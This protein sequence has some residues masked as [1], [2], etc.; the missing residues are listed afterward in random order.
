MGRSRAALVALAATLGCSDPVPQ[1]EALRAAMV[2][3]W[4]NSQDGGKTCWAYDFIDADGKALACNVEA[5]GG[6]SYVATAQHT[7]EA[8]ESCF[9][10]LGSAVPELEVGHRLCIQ[11]FMIDAQIHRF[12]YKSQDGEVVTLHRRASPPP[13]CHAP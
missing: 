10:I 11:S 8:A 5:R 13:R 4:C 6:L 1:G 2:G 9:V 7:V 3:A 12:Q